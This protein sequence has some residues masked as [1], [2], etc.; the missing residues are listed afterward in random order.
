MNI[1]FNGNSSF[2]LETRK[3]RRILL[4]PM[5]L[6]ELKENINPNI[7]LVTISH[8]HKG[9][10]LNSYFYDDTE[11][12]YTSTDFTNDFCS[13]KAIT[14]FHDNHNGQKRGPNII[15]KINCDGYYLCHLGHLGHKL[16]DNIINSLKE[17]DI[18]FVPVG[19]YFTIGLKDL[20]N[21]IE[22]I[23]PKYVIPMSY[24]IDKYSSYLK[25][26]DSFLL[27]F[28]NYNYKKLDYLPLDKQPKYSTPLIIIL[29]INKKK[30]LN[31]N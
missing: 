18:L 14:S 15:F 31:S 5:E 16:N 26:L 30:T 6:I 24:K 4:D 7:N 21:L 25:G 28:K 8:N 10:N 11:I 19:A 2:L 17:I 22:E 29:D 9:Q 23:N 27:K 12:L 1:Y 20:K 3:G 13:I